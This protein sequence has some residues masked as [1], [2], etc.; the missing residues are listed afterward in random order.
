VMGGKRAG[1]SGAFVHLPHS[2]C[3]LSSDFPFGA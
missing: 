2:F 3:F 1:M